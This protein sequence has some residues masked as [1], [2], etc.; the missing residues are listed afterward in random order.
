MPQ[1]TGHTPDAPTRA[2]GG[3]GDS[4][5]VALGLRLPQ[6]RGIV[7]RSSIGIQERIDAYVRAYVSRWRVPGLSISVVRDGAILFSA[8][9]GV[10]NL[11]T[12]QP[13]TAN[14][15]FHIA[16]VAKTM[17]SAAIF[18]LR[19]RGR[20]DLDDPI[21]KHLPYFEVDDARTDSITIR[22]CLTHTSGI[23]HPQ[24]YGWDK[25]EFD[26]G[27]LERHVRGLR[28]HKLVDV[29][30]GSTSYSDI[31]FNVLGDLIAK[32]SGLSYEQYMKEH[33]FDPL[34]MSTTT[35]MAS[36]AAH[37]ELVATG[38][39]QADDGGIV[40]SLYP[41]NRMHVPC[42]CIASS[43]SDMARWMGVNLQRGE[44]DGV[45][46]LQASTY[47]EMW[48]MQ[49]R[50]RRENDSEDPALGW[51]INRRHAQTVVQHDGEDDGFLSNLRLW[52]ESATGVVV[53]CNAQWCDPWKASDEVY[54]LA[55]SQSSGAG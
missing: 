45:R 41:Y 19:E 26:D 39:E 9:Y 2:E 55:L 5:R 47:D 44:L 32:V 27:A 54:A 34:G 14:T 48:R 52:T 24:D 12:R 51:W 49:F 16:S 3:A 13:A 30:P 31:A 50:T 35:L 38:Y 46:I 20:V 29:E 8:G 25:P 21:V 28:S 43:A 53:L 4:R 10:Q 33:I 37:P 11:A 17:T 18:Q 7:G 1:A 22:Q 36:R 6:E 40:Q 42:G 23:G 15:L